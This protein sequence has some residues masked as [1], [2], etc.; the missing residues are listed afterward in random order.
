MKGKV[1]KIRIMHF[2]QYLGILRKFK[3]NHT[4]LENDKMMGSN[5][6]SHFGLYSS[7]QIN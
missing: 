2:H 1:D 7:K 3:E 4:N 6:E 5:S